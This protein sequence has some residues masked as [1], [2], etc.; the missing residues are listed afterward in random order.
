MTVAD[1][2]AVIWHRLTCWFHLISLVVRSW[3]RCNPVWCA[4]WGGRVAASQ[5]GPRAYRVYVFNESSDINQGFYR[6][7]SPRYF[8]SSTWE[9]DV[10][11]MTGWSRFRVEVRYVL[12]QKKYRMIL[13]P[14]ET[15]AFPPYQ[16]PAAPA[17]RLPKGVLSARLQGPKGSDIDADVTSRVLKYQG[18][19]GDFH[20]GLG[21]KTYV[22]DMFPFD[23]HQENSTRFSHLRVMD[24]MA[25]VT[26]LPYEDNPVMAVAP[27]KPL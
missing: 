25:R 4:V 15:C 10:R 5:H 16:E 18:P 14:G 9:Q 8:D 13:R 7:I 22:H 11:D 20:A 12:R 3:V 17:C 26:D 27:V 6:E 2:A 19:R 1:R 21:L 24:T 23:D